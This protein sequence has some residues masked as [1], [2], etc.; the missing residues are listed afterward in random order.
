MSETKSL[1][2]EKTQMSYLIIKIKVVK[3]QEDQQADWLFFVSF[4][5]STKFE[6]TEVVITKEMEEE[7]KQLMKERERK[8]QEIMAKVWQSLI[9]LFVPLACPCGVLFLLPVIYTLFAN[10]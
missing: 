1:N 2:I 8:E 7:E 5:A 4:Q 3:G 9:W 10:L 6:T